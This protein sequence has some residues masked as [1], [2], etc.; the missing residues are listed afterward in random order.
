MWKSGSRR[1]NTYEFDALSIN[2]V[3]LL[4]ISMET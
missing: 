4:Q 1:E 3:D 2:G